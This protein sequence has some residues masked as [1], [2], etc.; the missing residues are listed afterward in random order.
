MVAG[1][2]GAFGSELEVR[3]ELD[4]IIVDLRDTMLRGTDPPRTVCRSL[5]V[6][7][8]GGVGGGMHGE[9]EGR[10]EETKGDLRASGTNAS[11][12]GEER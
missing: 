2:R 7:G 6:A 12:S 5:A 11:A 1:A 9:A 3:G 4:D 8:G 10:L